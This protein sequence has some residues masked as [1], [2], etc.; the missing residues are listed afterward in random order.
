MKRILIGL[1]FL[2]MF[3]FWSPKVSAANDECETIVI[4]CED[5]SQHIVVVCSHKDLLAWFDLLCGP[6]K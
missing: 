2:G 3:S 1:A 6:P 4:E 5:G